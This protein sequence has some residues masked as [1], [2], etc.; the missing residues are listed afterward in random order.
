MTGKLDIKSVRLQAFLERMHWTQQELADRIGVSRERVGQWNTE[1]QDVTRKD[2]GR[3][4]AAGMTIS[5]MFGE[6][7]AKAI[8]AAAVLPSE[9]Q[10]VGID[11]EKIV[12]EGLYRILKGDR[13]I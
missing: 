6:D 9:V 12:R 4:L 5:E 3:L 13:T 2:C 8:R 7:A 11:A 10:T 1:R